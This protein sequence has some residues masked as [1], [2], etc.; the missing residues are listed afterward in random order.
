MNP[1]LDHLLQQLYRKGEEHDSRNHIHE[2]RMLNITPDTG[3]FLSMLIQASSAKVVLEIGTSNGY[4]TLWLADA[5]S[6][7][8]GKVRTVEVS[9]IKHQMANENFKKSGLE[10]YIESTLQDVRSFLKECK[11]SSV[12]FV[13]LDA[14][15]LQYEEYWEDLDRVLRQNGLLVVDNATAPKPEEL[16]ALKNLLASSKRYTH[17]IIDVGKGELMALKISDLK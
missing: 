16:N 1:T 14:E 2:E 7:T 4:S 15:R 17:Q 12:D 9:K 6:R 10:N 3:S 11:D 5:V 13:F 8:G